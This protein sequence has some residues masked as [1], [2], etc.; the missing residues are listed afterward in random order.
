MLEG[1][2]LIGAEGGDSGGNSMIGETLDGAKRRKRLSACPTES[3]HLEQK[4]TELISN[5]Y[6]IG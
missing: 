4:S 2:P 3:V 1:Y 6:K 5:Q